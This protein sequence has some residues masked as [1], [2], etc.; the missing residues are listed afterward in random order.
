MG[1]YYKEEPTESLNGLWEVTKLSLCST[2]APFIAQ[3][4]YPAL[5][6]T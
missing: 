3:G 6:A 2:M 1:F 4:F 5:F